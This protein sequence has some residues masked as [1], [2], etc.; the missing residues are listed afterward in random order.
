MKRGDL[1][2]GT[3]FGWKI[4]STS[5]YGG[6]GYEGIV[7]VQSCVGQP[8]VSSGDKLQWGCRNNDS[9]Y[10]VDI[11]NNNGGFVKQ[12]AAC[13]E[14]LHSFSP[15]S[16]NLAAGDYKWKVWSNGGYGQNGFE[17]Q[18][19][20]KAA[21]VAQS[22]TGQSY[23]STSDKLQ[24]GCRS[25]DTFYCVDILNNNGGFVK[26]AAACSEGLHSFSPTSLNLASGDYKWKVWSNGG[27][28]GNNF[29]GNFNVAS[30]TTPVTTTSACSNFTYG[31]AAYNKCQTERLIGSWRL[32]YTSS[33]KAYNDSYTFI[34]PSIASKSTQGD[35]YIAATDIN[36]LASSGSVG[37]YSSNLNKFSVLH[38]TGLG[39]DDYYV[40]TL[41]EDGKTGSG[42]EYVVG[43]TTG[44]FY[45]ESCDLKVTKTGVTSQTFSTKTIADLSEKQ[46]LISQGNVIS[47]TP[48]IGE[49][50]RSLLQELK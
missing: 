50:F 41:S 44:T 34:S 1:M 26:Q 25:N 43:H 45:S 35:Y 38:T 18:F 46:A 27:Y 23:L 16:L 49:G 36:T 20:V 29:E 13:N 14:G 15:T 47:V 10:C 8:Y 17:G 19:T 9:F 30:K 24:W 22:C 28:G 40:F 11:L 37:G 42:C 48:E 33:G 39:F 31:T 6:N 2:P 7:T 3:K 4:W 12:A 21:T 5:G 32:S